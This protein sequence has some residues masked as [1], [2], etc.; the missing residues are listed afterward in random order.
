MQASN[1]RYWCSS[2]QQNIDYVS[3]TILVKKHGATWYAQVINPQNGEI[4]NLT[5][6]TPGKLISVTK[7]LFAQGLI[8]SID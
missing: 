8:Y 1:L 6:I 3:E 7:E 4:T 2:R 5:G